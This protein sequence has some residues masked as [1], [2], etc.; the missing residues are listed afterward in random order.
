MYIRLDPLGT[1]QNGTTVYQLAIQTDAVG[2]LRAFEQLVLA[3][4]L[5]D[6]LESALR[7]VNPHVDQEADIRHSRP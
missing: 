1:T 4:N 7:A 3:G 5:P 6:I 2:C